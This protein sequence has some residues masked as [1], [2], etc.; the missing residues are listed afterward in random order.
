MIVIKGS[1]PKEEY[2]ALLKK[3]EHI[4]FYL[5]CEIGNIETENSYFL[6][7]LLVDKFGMDEDLL[8]FIT[9]LSR[10]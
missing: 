1:Y 10:F 9:P 2:E 3:W 8:H 7:K 4:L 6:L 5:K